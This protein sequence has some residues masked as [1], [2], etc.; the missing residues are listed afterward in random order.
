[1]S[2]PASTA[3]R[4]HGDVPWLDDAEQAS[5]RAFLAMND[6]LFRH[7]ERGMQERSGLSRQDFA[8]LVHLSESPEAVIRPSDIGRALGWEQS[9]TSHQLA[10]MERRGLLRRH[11]CAEDGRGTAVV[12]SPAGREAIESAAPGHVRD[13]RQV[14]VDVLGRVGMAELGRMSRQVLDAIEEVDRLPPSMRRS[15]TVADRLGATGD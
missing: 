13:L 15:S 12:L 5:W 10:R 9:R 14:F 3:P 8:V 2:T 4:N 6:E 7:L 11:P 1:M